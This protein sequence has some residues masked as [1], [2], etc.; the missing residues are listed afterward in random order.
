[1]D[2]LRNFPRS[3]RTN[4]SALFWEHAAGGSRNYWYWNE[5]LNKK[6][7]EYQLGNNPP[8]SARAYALESIAFYDTMVAC[9]DAKYTYWAIRPFQL[10]P[11]FQPLFTTPNHPSYPAAHACL[12]IA[13]AETLAYLFPRDAS[14]VIELAEQAGESRIWAGIHYRSDVV[15]GLQLGR[16]VVNK[17]IQLAE[18]DGSQGP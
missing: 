15:T 14:Q 18:T 17:I 13:A 3:P 2:E 1:M 12:S 16:N 7:L 9:F 6:V 4:V 8:R 5:Q 10:D 11:T